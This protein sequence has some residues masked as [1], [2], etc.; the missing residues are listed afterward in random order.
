MRRVKLAVAA[1]GFGLVTGPCVAAERI[2]VYTAYEPDEATAYLQVARRDLPDIEVNLIRLSTGDLTARIMAEASDPKHDV[3]WGQAVTSLLDPGVLATLEPYE[4]NSIDRLPGRFRDRSGRWFAVT[5]YMTVLCVNHQR[6][7]ARKLPM[8]TSWHDLTDPIYQSEIVMPN[9]TA[10]GTGFIQIAS[11]LQDKGEDAGWREIKAIDANVAA[12][13]AS[14]STPCNEA[15]RGRYAIGVSLAERALR[16]IAEG[17]PITMVLPSEGAGNELEG[18][19]LVAS[20]K[21]K[22]AARRFLDW[23]L[24]ERALQEYYRWKAIVTAP[25]GYMPVTFRLAGLPADVSKAMF[26][27]NYEDAQRNRPAILERWQRDFQ[28]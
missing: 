16:N 12:Y 1:L 5:G 21:N 26:K 22:D 9:P 8:P 24:S 6:L 18:N 20:S 15:A 7:A 10:S 28:R 2:T 13:S 27:M 25:G 11:I 17:F 3:I 19:A 23:T 14:G 4:P